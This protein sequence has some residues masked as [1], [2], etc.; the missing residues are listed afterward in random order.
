LKTE[1]DSVD[2]Y[3]EQK[4]VFVRGWRREHKQSRSVKNKRQ[5]DYQ[6]E[7]KKQQSTRDKA[8]LTVGFAEEAADVFEG[9]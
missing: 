2:L 5:V 6:I 3:Y 1:G 4:E 9:F 7:K 8:G